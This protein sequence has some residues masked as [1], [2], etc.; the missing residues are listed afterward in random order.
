MFSLWTE[1]YNMMRQRQASIRRLQMMN[2]RELADIGI[3][4]GEIRNAVRVGRR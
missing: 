1:R 2:D 3:A 4:R